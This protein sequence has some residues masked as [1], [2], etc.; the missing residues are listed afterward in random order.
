M[1]YIIHIKA[2]IACFTKVTKITLGK[3]SSKNSWKVCYPNHSDSLI[4][5]QTDVIMWMDYLH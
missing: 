1:K 5:L 4:N 3:M 2:Y